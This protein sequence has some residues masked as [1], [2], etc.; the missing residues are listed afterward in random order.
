[1]LLKRTNVSRNTMRSYIIF[2]L[3][4][5]MQISS[6]LQYVRY[7]LVALALKYEEI[8]TYARN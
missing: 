5:L 4:I 6:T 1:M 7:L 2:Y 8:G 3:V